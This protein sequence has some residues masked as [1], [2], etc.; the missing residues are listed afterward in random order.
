LSSIT[1][2]SRNFKFVSFPRL[3]LNPATTTTTD[4][5]PFSSEEN[6]YLDSIRLSPLCVGLG[7]K[8]LLLDSVEKGSKASF[9]NCIWSTCQFVSWNWKYFVEII[10]KL[11]CKLETAP[12]TRFVLCSIVQSFSTKECKRERERAGW[13]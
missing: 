7:R 13:L 6:F 8:L 11:P 9:S 10:S 1:S 5:D 3:K 2:P 4:H 12:E